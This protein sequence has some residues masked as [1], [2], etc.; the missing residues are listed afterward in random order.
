MVN[1]TTIYIRL[2][3]IT[4]AG[5]YDGNITLTAGAT[6]TTVFMPASTVSPAPLTIAGINETKTYGT[7]L[8]NY[9]GPGKYVITAGNLKNGNT[10]SSV[11]IDYGTGADAGSPAGKYSGSVKPTVITGDN[12]FNATNY[13]VLFA[14][15][16]IIVLPANLTITANN[17]TRN[18]GTDNPILTFTYSGFVN[19]DTEAQLNTLPAAVTT[20][21]IASAPGKYPITVSGAA[22]ANY[23]FTYIKGVLTVIP[24]PDAVL[25]VPNTFTPNGDGI[26]DT[27]N[28]PALASY[29][30][31]TV[32]IYDRYG[33]VMFRSI[34]YPTPWDGR[35]NGKD[36]PTGVYYYIIDKKNNTGPVSG[37]LTV[38]R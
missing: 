28:L 17:E 24:L 37:S 14:N 25:V 15:A 35:H 18:Y 29:P 4:D 20:A 2:A 31:C 1:A 33:Q 38:L 30:N 12:G 10:I 8:Q 32:N 6:Q 13:I 27:W 3:A 19:G 21:T 9:T 5:P 34:G 26:N 7:A 22:S 23:T 11:S 36:V 16:D